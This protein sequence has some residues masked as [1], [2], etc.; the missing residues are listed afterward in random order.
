MESSF[1]DLVNIRRM[2]NIKR[3]NNFPVLIQEDVAQ[4]SYY[5]T[6]L[7]WNIASEYNNSV[8][9]E[10]PH[11][12][13]AMPYADVDEVIKKALCHDIPESITSDIPFNVKHSSK[14]M[15]EMVNTL[16]EDVVEDMSG[17]FSQSIS[18][19]ILNSK[20]DF[21]GQFVAIA[22]LLELAIYCAEEV[23]MGNNS[24]YYML[25]RCCELLQ[26]IDNFDLLYH[27]NFSPTFVDCFNISKQVLNKVNIVNDPFSI[28][29]KND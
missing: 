7:A 16:E 26:E 15:S 12:V 3:C 2:R 14:S 6:M 13:A 28:H 25:D 19:F 18:E 4:H 11:D 20:S 10:Y 23:N 8:D 1:V 9:N 22:D 17:V 5:V 27:K 21:N 29:I 24:L